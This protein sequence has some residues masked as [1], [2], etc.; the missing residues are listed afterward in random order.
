MPMPS[1]ISN[2]K[3][4]ATR[5][6][7]LLLVACALFCVFLEVGARLCFGRVSRI[8]HRR[9]AEYRG[10][11]AMRSLKSRHGESILVVGNSLLLEGVDFP[12]LRQEVAPEIELQ[13]TVVENTF[14]LDWYYG[15]RRIFRMGC[16]PDVVVVMLNP[17]QLT[18]AS[19]NGDYTAHLLVD[20]RDL[21]GFA[22][23]IG[24]DRN[25]LSSLALANWSSFYGTRA[26]IRSWILGK[27]LPA[28][29]H[30]FHSTPARP[31]AEAFGNLA[32]QRMAQ[33]R[34]LCAQYGTELVFVLPPARQDNGTSVVL[35]AASATRVKVLSPIPPG[36]LPSSDYADDF[37]LNSTGAARFTPLLADGLKQVL[38][39][40]AIAPVEKL[41]ASAVDVQAPSKTTQGKSSTQPL[42]TTVVHP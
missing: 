13:R 31:K 42:A 36:V 24:A 22:T 16:Q 6:V 12:Q 32:A 7:V 5:N 19:V 27:I 41:A 30:L 35:Q 28:L 39:G 3:A 11:L 21:L 25:A 10:A 29:P 33:L 37:H 34:D 8:E 23:D 18:S 40:P 14:Y 38:G 17:I 15:L 26:E 2:S 9:Q 4:T 20:H 1:S